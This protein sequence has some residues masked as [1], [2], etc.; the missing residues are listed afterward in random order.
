MMSVW[1]VQFLAPI[2]DCH[3]GVLKNLPVS[4]AYDSKI[5]LVQLLLLDPVSSVASL[6]FA[7]DFALP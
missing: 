4:L 1:L 5:S 2:V 3:D 7:S 6:A